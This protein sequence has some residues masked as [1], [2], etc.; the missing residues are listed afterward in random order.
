MSHKLVLASNNPGK[1]RELQQLL[2]TRWQLLAQ[3]ALGVEPVAE[4]GTSFRDNALRVYRIAEADRG[5][6]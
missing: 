1:L 3:S 4:T 6:R 5:R 2:G